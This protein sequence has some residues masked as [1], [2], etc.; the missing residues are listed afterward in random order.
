MEQGY[1]CGLDA[2]WVQ[3]SLLVGAELSPDTK[4]YLDQIFELGAI[5]TNFGKYLLHTTKV[6][7]HSPFSD[8]ISA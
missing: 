4:F 3:F 7:S 5:S 6:S 8:L 1:W 2:V